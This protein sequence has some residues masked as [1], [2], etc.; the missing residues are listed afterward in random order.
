MG[1]VIIVIVQHTS[2]I[3]LGPPIAKVEEVLSWPK[4][5]WDTFGNVM[6]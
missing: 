5:F 3:N 1:G 2:P 6:A 4:I